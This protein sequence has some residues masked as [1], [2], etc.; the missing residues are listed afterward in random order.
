MKTLNPY[1]ATT[2]QIQR[3][4]Q[5]HDDELLDMYLDSIDEDCERPQP[6]YSATAD[7]S[8]QCLEFRMG[9]RR[10]VQLNE[11]GN[12]DIPAFLRGME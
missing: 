4:G 8:R 2:S 6:I 12:I 11:A 3:A 1:T 9:E 10:Q 5:S 7:N